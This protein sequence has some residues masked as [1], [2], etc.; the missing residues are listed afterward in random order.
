MVRPIKHVDRVRTHLEEGHRVSALLLQ[1]KKLLAGTVKA[2]EK[3]ASVFKRGGTLFIAGNGGSAADAQHFA[4]EL[5]GW[6][7]KGS[8]P[9]KAI[10]LTTDTSFLTAW[11]NDA[12][13]EDVFVRQLQALASRGDVLFVMSTSGN[14]P[15][16]LTALKAAKKQGI[17]TIALLGSGGAARTLADIQ[18]SVP[19]TV[20]AHIQEAH[21]AIIHA[22]CE[23]L[24]EEE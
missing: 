20:T 11:A 21:I 15:N 18:I 12:A 22:I 13:F 3:I 4:A 16:V 10:A 5:V 8:A 7:R 2:A 9:Q 24:T 19:S 1:D 23:C 17:H 6:Y 14:S